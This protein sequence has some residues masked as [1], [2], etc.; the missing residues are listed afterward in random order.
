M[1]ESK[2]SSSGKAPIRESRTL[3]DSELPT[4]EPSETGSPEATDTQSTLQGTTPTQNNPPPATQERRGGPPTALDREPPPWGKEY[5]DSRYLYVGLPFPMPMDGWTGNEEAD[6]KA[7]VQQWH[8]L[9]Y[10]FRRTQGEL[11]MALVADRLWQERDRQKTQHYAVFKARP[12]TYVAPVHGVNVQNRQTHR[13]SAYNQQ[14]L[15]GSAQNQQARGGS[16]LTAAL[17]QSRC[18]DKSRAEHA[19]QV[20][21]Q[22]NN[23][24]LASE[25]SKPHLDP[26]D[27]N[28][29][30]TETEFGTLFTEKKNLPPRATEERP[31]PMQDIPDTRDQTQSGR[32]SNPSSPSKLRLRNP[33]KRK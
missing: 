11:N 22:R 1:E 13:G 28:W 5:S 31:A 19:P 16:A 15:G 17:D 12:G 14:A 18:S 25:D 24:C 33:F 2:P 10:K 30:E 7:S 27:P 8:P 20:L 26:D 29:Q 3:S 4:Q 6:F 21:A 32:A 9:S 23:S